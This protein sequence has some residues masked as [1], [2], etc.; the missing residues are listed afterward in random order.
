MFI[1]MLNGAR[2][3]P[4][5]SEAWGLRWFEWS[6]CGQVR[7]SQAECEWSMCG[8]VRL[9][10]AEWDAICIQCGHQFEVLTIEVPLEAVRYPEDRMDVYRASAADMRGLPCQQ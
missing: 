1:E 10:Q 4:L 6:M 3:T 9:S 5:D 2:V 8:Q 7:L